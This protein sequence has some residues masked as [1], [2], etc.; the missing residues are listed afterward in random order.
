MP[1]IALPVCYMPAFCTAFLFALLIHLYCLIAAVAYRA[2]ARTIGLCGAMF[3]VSFFTM[4]ILT[5]GCYALY[6]GENPSHI[7]EICM[8]LP[9]FPAA[10]FGTFLIAIGIIAYIRLIRWRNGHISRMSIKES[11][12]ILPTG[13]AFGFAD[14]IPRLINLRMNALGH[15][16]T[17]EAVSDMDAFWKTVAGGT[18]APGNERVRDGESPILQITDGTVWTF[19]RKRL[20]RDGAV[21]TQFTAVDT[22]EEYLLAKQLE[23][24]NRRL[25]EMNRRLR[26]YGKTVRE[27]TREK[28]LLEAKTRVHDELGHALIASR[29][30]LMAQCTPAERREIVSLWHQSVSIL[31]KETLRDRAV[32]GYEQLSKAAK[33]IGARIVWTGARPKEGTDT[34]RIL[35]SAAH[36][37]LTN[38]VRHAS[39]TELYVNAQICAEYWE[40]TLTNNG[41]APTSEIR[42]G[43]GLISLRRRVEE[44]YGEMKLSH[45]PRF[46]LR[47]TIPDD[48]EVET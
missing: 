29:R 37:C 47:I 34:A 33:A 48:S 45:T 30:L 12:D 17:G 27:A 6:R 7:L 46:E 31:N 20:K 36:E 22:T 2:P 14:S 23:E 11:V 13:L 21:I 26:D 44:A 1:F 4:V 28:E 24:E 40:F 32:D 42:E 9:A 43:S 38:A 19:E 18:L 41:N 15:A 10:L 8:R 35:Q 25:R 16:L 5:A 39:G 3:G